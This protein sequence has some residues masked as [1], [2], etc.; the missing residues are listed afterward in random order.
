MYSLTG[1][2]TLALFGSLL[3]ALTPGFPG[4]GPYVDTFILF[5]IFVELF[6][7]HTLMAFQFFITPAPAV[8]IS[9]GLC[10]VSLKDCCRPYEGEV[11]CFIGFS[12]S[13]ERKD[14]TEMGQH[15]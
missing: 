9:L 6:K 5:T 1:V 12:F 8:T 2:S 7:Q 15:P 10:G 4:G 13:V 3:S 14:Q 11:D